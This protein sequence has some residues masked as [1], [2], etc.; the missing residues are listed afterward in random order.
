MIRDETV[1][2]CE[3]RRTEGFFSTR[4]QMRHLC[5]Y[6][7]RVGEE[8]TRE[9]LDYAGMS[10]KHVSNRTMDEKKLLENM[11]RRRVWLDWCRSVLDSGEKRAVFTRA[12]G[13]Q[14]LEAHG[15]IN[16]KDKGFLRNWEKYPEMFKGLRVEK[17]ERGPKTHRRNIYKITKAVE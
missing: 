2:A 11:K 7:I 6:L 3:R 13:G 5:G 4:T 16:N 12:A 14:G 9:M 15:F 8:P 17:I 1:I 10:G